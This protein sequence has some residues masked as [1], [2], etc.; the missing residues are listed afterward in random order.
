LRLP[1]FVFVAGAA[2]VGEQAQGRPWL[3]LLAVADGTAAGVDTGVS[4]ST[5]RRLAED[6]DNRAL[7]FYR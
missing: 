5:R 4:W 3:V 2:A 7:I 1:D 6:G